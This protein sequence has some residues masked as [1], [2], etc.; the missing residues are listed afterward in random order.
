MSKFL[1]TIATAQ[2]QYVVYAGL[3]LSVLIC[4][5]ILMAR[6]STLYQVFFGVLNPILVIVG[7]SLLGALLLTYLMASGWFAIFRPPHL[8]AT[9]VAAAVALLF[10]AAMILADILI[11]FPADVNRLFPES[12]PFYYSIA[13][14]VEVLFH[15][16]PLSILLFFLNALPGELN[17]ARIIWPCIL[18]V[19]LLEPAFQT[20]MGFSRVYP[21]WVTL[22]VAVHIYLFNVAQLAVFQRYDFVSMLSVR[23]VYYLLWHILWGMLRLRW[24]F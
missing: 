16:L 13:F 1:E 20:V 8:Q 14:V 4:A 6:G 15:L 5:G 11:V 2:T 19:A 22:F 10:A 24:L 7:F 18:L 17:F 23:L 21:P 12:L 9:V 3:V